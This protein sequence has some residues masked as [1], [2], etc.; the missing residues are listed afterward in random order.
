MQTSKVLIGY[1][2]S[3]HA[4]TAIADLLR[5]GLPDGTE[6]FVATV[7]EMWIRMPLSF[8]GVE[9]SYVNPT[10]TGESQAR[11]TA[12]KGADKVMEMFPS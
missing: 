12:K 1:D 6:A 11:K 2:G 7:S 5:A 3:D 9:T 4:E 10:I 8:G